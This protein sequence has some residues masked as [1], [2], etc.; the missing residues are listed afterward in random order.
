MPVTPTSA[1]VSANSGSSDQWSPPITLTFGSS[2]TG[3]IA[4]A[5]DRARRGALAAGN[6]G[7]LE[8]R[9]GRRGGGDQPLLVAEHDLGVGADIDQERDLLAAMRAFGER[10]AGGV[11]ADMA[12]DA[13]EGVDAR[14]FVDRQ[15]DVAGAEVQR[16]G[17]GERERRAAELGRVDA[18]EEVVH[19][20][21][22]DED[23]LEDL[24]GG[25]RRPRRRPFRS[26]R[27]SPRA[28]PWSSPRARPGSSSRRRRGSSDPRR[29]GSAGSACRRR[30]AC[31][32]RAARRDGR[33]SWSS[34]CR[35]RCPQAK[36]C[37]PG[38][39]AITTG[40]PRS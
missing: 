39:S 34:R 33:R 35:R 3:S 36:L 23:A 27:R 6:L 22:A 37:R 19:D 17:D 7:A 8:G 4:H 10:R 5:L 28:P 20:R 40:P 13:G 32:R 16:V 18:E 21:V 11:G 24:V 26:A 30:R 15:A 1:A 14:A 25:D 2:V 38:Q 29:S 12:G 31:A 9:A